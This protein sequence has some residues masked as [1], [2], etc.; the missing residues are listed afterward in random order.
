VELIRDEI[1]ASPRQRITFA[2]FMDRALTEPGLGYYAR[3]TLRPTR[4]GDFLT[5]PELHPFFGRCLGR[6]IS[7]AWEQAGAAP[8]YLVREY[9]A[10]RGTLRDTVIAGLVADGS[11]LRE[12]LEWQAV[13][14]PRGSGVAS[15]DDAPD[16]VLANEYLDAL[17]VHRV[18]QQ[19]EL[20]EVYVGWQEG[21][22][23]EII[24]APSSPELAA[25]LAA[26][27]VVL[28]SGQRAEIRLAA[29]AWMR[30]VGRDARLVLIIDYG[31]QAAQLYGPQRMAGSLLTYRE[32]SVS[33]EPFSAVGRSDIT[34]H[35]DITALAQAASRA[36][37]R[38]VGSASQASFLV[39]LGLG[40]LLGDLGR[41][42]QTEAA[43]YVAAR[44]AVA[45][46]IDPR[47]LGDFRVLA[48]S[49]DAPG[50]A[51]PALP[52][53]GVHA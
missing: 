18:T 47:H 37:L 10:G 14:L 15:L 42:P 29:S 8:R 40:E 5:A 49:R 41:D 17:P 46:L 4:D 51:S 24:D 36:G 26:D 1:L 3:S 34:A 20:R 6:F 33:D 19:E 39:A 45:R 13:D 31:H 52:G 50:A 21:W 2:R 43:D 38:H 23:I 32:H 7:A 22:F 27:D 16:L 25:H 12:A 35:V 44:S 11:A 28:A 9:G 30:S 53:F 48:W